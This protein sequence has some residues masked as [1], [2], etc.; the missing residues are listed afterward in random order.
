MKVKTNLLFEQKVKDEEFKASFNRS[1]VSATLLRWVQIPAP[2][3]AVRKIHPSH[4]IN[5]ANM[6]I[7]AWIGKVATKNCLPFLNAVLKTELNFFLQ[8]KWQ[9]VKT[10]EKTVWHSSQEKKFF[11]TKFYDLLS[12]FSAKQYFYRLA[13]IKQDI[14]RTKY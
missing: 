11:F 3:W 12:K 8:K 10:G 7:N 6:E 4:T 14:K 5:E 2:V 1:R 13:S 9:K